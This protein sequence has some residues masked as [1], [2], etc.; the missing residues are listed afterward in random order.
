[1]TL[2]LHY[3]LRSDVGL[4]R[5]GN[6]DSAYAGPNLLALADGMGGYA[7]GEVAS[8]VAINALIPLDAHR[9]PDS[10]ML[11]AL[12]AAVSSANRTLR[13]MSRADPSTEG[14]GTTLTAM[15][16]HGATVG[17]VHIGDSRGY[18]LRDGKLAQITTDHTLVQS[19][20]DDGLLSRQAAATHPQR[21]LVTRAL[22]TSTEADPDLLM[23]EARLGDRYLL[24]S[25]GLSDVVTEETIEK[26]LASAASPDEAVDRL[27][28]LAIRGGGP[29]NITCV[30]ADVVDTETGPVPPSRTAVAVGAVSHEDERPHTRADSPAGRA[31]LLTQAAQ[32]PPAGPPPVAQ[33]N[34]YHGDPDPSE[35]DEPGRRR[36]PLVT[37]ILVVLILLVAGG[38]YVAWRI[39]QSQY[40][41]GNDGGFVVIY[42][43]VN[44]KVAGLTLWSTYQRTGIPVSEVDGSILQLPTA[45]STLAEA[46]HTVTNI[47]HTY[48]CKVATD[49]VRKWEANKPKPPARK[50]TTKGGKSSKSGSSGHKS[51]SSGTGSDAKSKSSSTSNALKNYPPKPTIPSYC[52]AQGGG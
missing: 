1:M 30:V 14:M 6:E 49:A 7:A 27:I 33:H 5:E 34:G 11:D 51:K 10:Q 37:S 35:E 16:W 17:M 9:P 28:G 18:M 45:S 41:V 4:L 31:H 2:A 38:G 44:Q 21:S 12:G 26:T 15:L 47:R 39:T 42:R 36:W 40:Y 43:G 46:Q 24:C 22:Q 29:D 19:L 48:Q 32:A 20:V 25:D 3:A 8:A 50:K 52:G 13:E 23:H